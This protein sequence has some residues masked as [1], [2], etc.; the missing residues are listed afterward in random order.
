MKFVFLLVLSLISLSGLAQ[1][2]SS[3]E[4]YNMAYELHKAGFKEL[5]ARDLFNEKVVRI[6]KRAI[7]EN[8]IGKQSKEMQRAIIMGSVKGQPAE[9]FFKRFPVSLNIMADL[10]A[11]KQAVPGLLDILLRKD[12]LKTFG[13]ISLTLAIFGFL[14]RRFFITKKDHILKRILIQACLSVVVACTTL[15]IFYMMFE[16]E[17]SPTI[18]IVKANLG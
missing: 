7:R 2:E 14:V 10:V 6:I 8:E 9:D 1:E 12:D 18:R 4:P 13:W 15:S 5:S 16:Q 3:S 17:I 11:D